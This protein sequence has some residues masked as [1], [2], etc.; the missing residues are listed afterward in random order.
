MP[1]VGKLERVKTLLLDRLKAAH[2]Y[3]Y[4]GAELELQ[5][6]ATESNFAQRY[7]D[8]LSNLYDR[9]KATLPETAID[10]ISFLELTRN[11][12]P[13]SIKRN[14]FTACIQKR[15]DFT[16]DDDDEEENQQAE[17]ENEPPNEVERAAL[18]SAEERVKAQQA[19]VRREPLSPFKPLLRGALT[20]VSARHQN[21]AWIN[22]ITAKFTKEDG[23]N[24]QSIY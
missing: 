7:L 12:T 3:R 4:E 15:I 6:L 14:S 16:K 19:A 23:S 20:P 21:L 17:R 9:F 24:V 10:E 11:L 22:G 5:R 8:D 13:Q 18:R 1:A 2:Q